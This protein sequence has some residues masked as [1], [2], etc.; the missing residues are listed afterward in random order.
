MIIRD[1][2][3]SQVGFPS[4]TMTLNRLDSAAF[5]ISAD[6]TLEFPWMST[7]LLSYSTE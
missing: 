6:T 4:V 5:R 2:D 1:P 7:V 3:P